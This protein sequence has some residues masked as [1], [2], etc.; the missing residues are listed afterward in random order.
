MPSDGPHPGD[1]IDLLIPRPRLVR[2]LGESM[3]HAAPIRSLVRTRGL[4]DAAW[5][6]QGEALGVRFEVDR[7]CMHGG[8]RL[9]VPRAPDD[10]VTLTAGDD[11]GFRNGRATLVQ[12]AVGSEYQLTRDTLPACEIEDAPAFDVRGV[13]LDVSRMRVPTMRRLFAIVDQLALLKFNHLQLYV[14][15]TFLYSGHE[16]V[17]SGSSPITADELRRL[18]RYAR[19]RGLTLAANQNCFGHMQRW[20][21]CKAYADLAE[22]HGDWMFQDMPRH[23][24]FSLCPTDPRSIELVD[25]LISQQLACVSSRLINIGCDET[26]DVG[27]GRSSEAVRRLGRALVYGRFVGQVCQRALAR[28]ARPMFWADIALEHPDALAHVPD[29]AIALVWGYEPSAAFSSWCRSCCAF[30]HEVWVCPGTS[31]WRSITGRTRERRG[32]MARA[33]REGLAHGAHGVLV[34]DWGDAGHLQ[35]WPI[36]LH[37]L[38]QAADANWTGS[39][40]RDVAQ[41]ES[42]Q[43]FGDGTG[44]IGTWLD[45]LGDVDVELRAAMA[46][47]PEGAPPLHNATALFTALWPAR[48]GYVLPN[49]AEMWRMVRLRLDALA[50]S[51]PKGLSALVRDELE[52]TLRFAKF[53]TDVGAALACGTSLPQDCKPRLE[54]LARDHERLWRITSRPGGLADSLQSFARLWQRLAH[55]T[56]Q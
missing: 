46:N 20:L 48:D 31:S 9:C 11:D 39:A 47:P 44:Q 51:M 24:A 12:L 16:Q 22:T 13:M 27:Q 4:E 55:C 34:C 53:A 35:Q 36:S 38:A 18:D 50:G 19:S 54:R 21:A 26:Y 52:H 45:E 23:S 8:Y 10:C 28:G 14:E 29:E 41:A 1:P 33:V 25:D 40:G 7:S 2:L 49:D 42:V 17:A 32:N 5:Q 43:V 37:A 6:A 56:N 30:G 15:H 3:I